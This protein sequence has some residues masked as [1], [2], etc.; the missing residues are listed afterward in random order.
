MRSHARVV[1]IG[2]GV[3]GCSVAYHLARMGL[4]DTVLI[5][6][7]ELTSGSSWHAAGSLFS[8]TAPAL[9]AEMQKYTRA[10]YPVLEQESGQPIGHHVTGGYS[11]ARSDDE[12][13]KLKALSNRGLRHGIPSAFHDAAE[14]KRRMPILNTDGVKAFLWEDE[15][16]YVDPASV[17]QAYAKAARL[18][19]VEIIRHTPVTATRKLASGEWSVETPAG[20]VRCEYV[21]NA[22]G[23]W[24]RE[25]AALAGIR[26]P[27]VPVE[28]HYLVTEAI[29]E[30]EAMT[31]DVPTVSDGEANW[32]MR[33]EGK[34]L[35]LGAYENRCVHWAENG[36]PAEF[37]HELLPDDLSRMDE[38]FAN[39]VERVPVLATA[40]IKRVINGP[41]IFSPDLAPLLGPWP[42]DPTYMCAA[43]VMT[44]FN[45]GGGVGKLVAEWIVE[46]EPAMDAT[47]WD[48]ARYGDW[49]GRAYTTARSKYWYEHRSHRVYPYQQIEA[50]RPV[51]TSPAYAEMKARGGVFGESFGMEIPMWF[52]K[53]DEPQAESYSYRRPMWL[54]AVR[55]ESKATAEAVGLYETSPYAKFEVLGPDA[56]SWLDFVLAG[57]LPEK[58]GQAVLSPMLSHQGKLIGDFTVSRLS[59]RRYLL[60]GSGSMQQA[61][62]RWFRTLL[63]RDGSV[64]VENRSSVLAGLHIAG[65]NARALLARLTAADV[66]NEALPFLGVRTMEIGPCPEAIVIR[67]SYTGELG[68]ELYMATEYQEALLLAL[69]EAGRDLG[70][71]LCGTRALMSLRLEKGWPSFGL[72]VSGDYMPSET[73][74]SRFVRYGK[75]DFI[76]KAPAVA[77]QRKR[78]SYR[79]ALLALD[80]TGLPDDFA[81]ASGGESLFAAGEYAG[82]VTSGGFGPRTGLSLAMAYVQP[83]VAGNSL[84]VEVTGQRVPVRVLEAIPYDPEGLKLRG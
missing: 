40:G 15:K 4:S 6:R 26:L 39:A 13:L 42:S 46:G 62:M 77:A 14:A 61:N 60:V 49:T 35:L 18:R 59:S 25:V 57:R 76:G 23:L 45:Q 73:V 11:F 53:G 12:V 83:D 33:Q 75:D 2:G 28:H 81:D 66:S 38:N 58:D 41:M 27:L 67:V 72:D 71:A 31:W 54:A 79:P 9:A 34:G 21:V 56:G 16:G 10:L 55:R 19:G 24:A 8:L 47:A 3:T 37:G 74:L 78:L 43:G 65:P 82:Y 7:Q 17:T 51:R 63:P 30:I 32:Y 20:A 48:V 29:P 22:A 1:V 84:D 69:L 5:E 44:A 70:L 52:A 64:K 36:T 50:G 68:Y 80:R